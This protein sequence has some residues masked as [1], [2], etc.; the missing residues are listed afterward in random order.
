MQRIS[1]T[2]YE[3][4]GAYS[5]KSGKDYAHSSKSSKGSKRFFKNEK[6]TVALSV[7]QKEAVLENKSTAHAMS[8]LAIIL[9]AIV[10]TGYF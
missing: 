6:Q 3:P 9:V 7:I 1:E 8:P 10:F 4:E 5:S 2:G